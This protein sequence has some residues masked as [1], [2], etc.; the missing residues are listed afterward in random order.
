M[1]S[2][3]KQQIALAE[4]G[5]PLAG[6]DDT[7]Q[8]IIDAAES[9]GGGSSSD[10]A[11]FVG[12]TFFGID[13]SGP[14]VIVDFTGPNPY[15]GIDRYWVRGPGGGNL[16][17]ISDMAG[18]YVDQ[19][20]VGFHLSADGSITKGRTLPLPSTSSGP[21]GPSGPAGPLYPGPQLGTRE[22]PSISG[23][24]YIPNA[25][26]WLDGLL[27]SLDADMKDRGL[28]QANAIAQFNAAVQKIGDEIQINIQNANIEQDR[29]YK[30][31]LL[32][33]D[34][35]SAQRTSRDRAAADYTSNILPFQ[36]PEGFD[37]NLPLIGEVPAIDIDLNELYDISGI[38]NAPQPVVTAPQVDPIDP[39]RYP[40]IPDIPQGGF[41]YDEII[42][43]F[44][45]K[46]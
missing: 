37:L 27:A 35:F 19:F 26:D 16:I 31:G 24:F 12:I 44:F 42:Q 8:H 40:V 6:G 9:G 29:S 30:Q 46:I 39:D 43:N 14:Y 17:P 21:S 20:N 41:N 4:A 45:G 3:I 23:S 5:V 10:I 2:L 34:R 1:T 33:L 18:S 32:D 36:I 28:P 11:G 13:G 15:A 7:L 38:N 25:L 22:N